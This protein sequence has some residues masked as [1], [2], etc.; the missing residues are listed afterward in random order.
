MALILWHLDYYFNPR[1]KGATVWLFWGGGVNGRGQD[2][3][4]QVDVHGGKSMGVSQGW[5]GR[6]RGVLTRHSGIY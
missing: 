3:K 1:G 2:S 4:H 5:F 6:G